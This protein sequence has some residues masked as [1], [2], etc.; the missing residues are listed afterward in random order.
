MRIQS[1]CSITVILVCYSSAHAFSQTNAIAL[2]SGTASPGGAT[3]LSL[4]LTSP[5]GNEPAVLHWTLVY[6][7][8][9]IVAVTASIGS[10][11]A[12]AGKS[13]SCNGSPGAYTCMLT[14]VSTNG[15]NANMIQNGVV[16]VATATLSPSTTTTSIAITNA[17]GATPS[18]NSDPLSATGG[19]VT[20]ILPLILTSLNCSPGTVAS[21]AYATCTVSLNEAAPASGGAISLFSNNA[22]LT[23]P[24]TVTVAAGS[25]STTFSATVAAIATNQTAAITASLSGSLESTTLAL[26]AQVLVSALACNSTNLDAGAS[27][28]CTITLSAP[29]PTSGVAVSISSNGPALTV[30]ASVIVAA[31]SST[32]NFT[33]TAT[34]EPS[35]SE[36]TETVQVTTTLNGSSQAV[37]FT[38]T[39]CPCSE[40]PST[41]TPVNPSSTNT[42]AIEVGMQF[43]S[44]LAGYVT[45]VRFFKGSG[46]T[47]PHVGNLWSANRAHMAQVTFTR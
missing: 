2:S 27:S 6:S 8:A 34:T 33:A 42:E 28:V 12:G 24:A 19:T 31:G 13:L 23:V 30:P 14:G 7:P 32:A 20:T 11:A 25:F 38:L 41:A 36:S 26:I 10:A 39:I 18:A 35:G 21:G 15:L 43:T 4:S 3:S 1:M 44:S 29:D 47:G 9:D 5:S 45:G 22:S 40:W 37:S 46:N 17:L 16:A